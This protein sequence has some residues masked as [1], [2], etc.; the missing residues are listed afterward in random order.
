MPERT[1]IRFKLDARAARAGL[2]RE[3][4]VLVKGYPGDSP[5]Y[6]SLETSDGPKTLALGP[7]YR[8]AIDADFLNEARALLGAE[9]LQ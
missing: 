6:V 5:V 2:V 3:L 9:A 8:V 1:E 7:A 4:A